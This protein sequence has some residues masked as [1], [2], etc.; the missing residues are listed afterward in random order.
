MAVREDT[1]VTPSQWPI[2]RI[3]KTYPGKDGQVRVVD[4][5]TSSGIYKRPITKLVPLLSSKPI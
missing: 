5:R 1:F 4:V 2:A 3:V